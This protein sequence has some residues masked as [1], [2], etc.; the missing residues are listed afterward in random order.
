MICIQ[1][2][3]GWLGV[4]T[5]TVSTWLK[6]TSVCTHCRVCTPCQLRMPTSR[7]IGVSWLFLNNVQHTAINFCWL[8][9]C[10]RKNT[11]DWV[12][13]VLDPNLNT[14]SLRTSAELLFKKILEFI[15]SL[16]INNIKIIKDIFSTTTTTH[17]MGKKTTPN[18]KIY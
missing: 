7:G 13:N 17:P 18:I 6:F 15:I 8:S 5:S 16:E 12:W 3:T 1:S 4:N 9:P 11:L 10:E 2:R 14:D